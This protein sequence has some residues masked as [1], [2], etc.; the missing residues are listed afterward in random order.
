MRKVILGTFAAVVVLFGSPAWAGG[1]STFEFGKRFDRAQEY[2]GVGE[3]VVGHM[4]AGFDDGDDHRR[5]PFYAYLRSYSTHWRR[6]P[7]IAIDAVPLG[8]IDLSPMRNGNWTWVDASLSFTV[9]HVEPGRYL[10][11]YCNS[12]CT[13]AM[14][15]DNGNWPTFVVVTATATEAR[16]RMRLDNLEARLASKFFRAN[17]RAERGVRMAERDFE[18]D[19]LTA[20]RIGALAKRIETLESRP[21]RGR[22][23][24][25]DQAWLP[26]AVAA[27]MGGA[28]S[29]FVRGVAKKAT[30]RA[31]R[32]PG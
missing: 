1:G 5:G 8:R 22:E 6:P 13:Y 17:A 12:P 26:I 11:E 23:Q 16:L 31:K 28:A 32:V 2:L 21:V 24:P 7:N 10:I 27:A 15:Q 9:P 25:T 4:G 29:F 14:G 30:E 20:A 18:D 19:A 3:R